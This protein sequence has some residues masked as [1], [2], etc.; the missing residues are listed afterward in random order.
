MDQ[1]L[2]ETNQ[3]FAERRSERQ[4]GLAFFV[5]DHHVSRGKRSGFP[6]QVRPL[7]NKFMSVSPRMFPVGCQ[8][9]FCRRRSKLWAIACRVSAKHPPELVWLVWSTK[10]GG[11]GKSKIIQGTV[12]VVLVLVGVAWILHHSSGCLSSTATPSTLAKSSGP[13]C[14]T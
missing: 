9:L 11:S 5:A 10:H 4:D 14:E 2:S 12:W 3:L 7:S 8:G 6:F 1:W 13:K